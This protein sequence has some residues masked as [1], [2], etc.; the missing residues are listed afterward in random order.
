MEIVAAAGAGEGSASAPGLGPREGLPPSLLFLSLGCGRG[1]S[2]LEDHCLRALS[3]L[4][5]AEWPG[6][7]NRSG[8]RR[9]SLRKPG[10]TACVVAARPPLCKRSGIGSARVRCKAFARGGWRRLPAPF[11]YRGGGAGRVWDTRC[12]SVPLEGAG[13][14]V[15][16]RPPAGR[17]GFEGVIGEPLE[18]GRPDQ[19]VWIFPRRVSSRTPGTFPTRVVSRASTLRGAV[20][21]SLHGSS[22]ISNRGGRC[23]P[24][25]S[26]VIRVTATSATGSARRMGRPFGPLANPP[27]GVGGTP[28]RPTRRPPPTWPPWG[29][30]PDRPLREDGLYAPGLRLGEQ[31][32]M[33]I[34][35]AWVGFCFWIR[36]LPHR[37][38]VERVRALLPSP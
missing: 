36:G 3:D 23:V 38:R 24:K 12:P 16:D 9:A 6:G 35:A 2:V 4:A 7:P 8:R 27:T 37:P 1:S 29:R 30:G 5:R 11:T 15:F 26:S 22:S 31:R 17:M 34:L 19:M 33:A 18:G 32:G 20:T 10:I 13:T 28:Q 21:T 14:G 25:P